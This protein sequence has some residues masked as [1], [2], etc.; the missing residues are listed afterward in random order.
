MANNNR[1]LEIYPL[2]TLPQQPI[3]APVSKPVKKRSLWQRLFTWN[4]LFK[5]IAIGLFLGGLVLVIAGAVAATASFPPFLA[6]LVTIGAV[7]VWAVGS[8]KTIYQTLAKWG[9]ALDGDTKPLDKAEEILTDIDQ[10][11]QQVNY[12]LTALNHQ[13][14]KNTQFLKLTEKIAAVDKQ[15]GHDL[16]E[17]Y[18]TS[19]KQQAAKHREFYQLIHKIARVDRRLAYKL[20]KIYS[21]DHSLQK[22]DST[23]KLQKY[24]GVLAHKDKNLAKKLASVYLEHQ[25]QETEISHQFHQIRAKIHKQQPE[26]AKELHGFACQDDGKAHFKVYPYKLERNLTRSLIHQ[27]ELKQASA[28]KLLTK[29]EVYDEANQKRHDDC[30]TKLSLS[31]STVNNFHT[32][33]RLLTNVYQE[34]KH[35]LK[36]VLEKTKQSLLNKVKA[37]SPFKSKPQPSIQPKKQQ[38]VEVEANKSLEMPISETL[39]NQGLFA[40]AAEEPEAESN[41][42]MIDRPKVPVSMTVSPVGSC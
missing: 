35:K 34:F 11:S 4:T 28:H 3:S 40:T 36:D 24:Y 37:H 20:S 15:A 30:Q 42:D 23:F 16:G 9:S 8:Y 6:A 7:S 13:E 5:G 22:Q 10:L 31:L 41:P 12:K 26:L 19:A 1:N 21:H 2:L 17:L 33:L 32:Q 25:Q 38:V 27:L 14:Q 18:S 29:V 39:S